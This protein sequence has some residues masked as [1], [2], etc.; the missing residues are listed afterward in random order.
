MTRTKRCLC[1]FGPKKKFIQF[2]L[3]FCLVRRP[4]NAYRM[5]NNALLFL[6]VEHRISNLIKIQQTIVSYGDLL[7][8][9]RGD[10]K[11]EKGKIKHKSRRHQIIIINEDDAMWCAQNASRR[12][13]HVA[14]TTDAQMPSN[15]SFSILRATKRETFV[16]KWSQ[17][18][19]RKKT[20]NCRRRQ[21]TKHQIRFELFLKMHVHRIRNAIVLITT[22][23]RIQ[24]ILTVH[25]KL[26]FGANLSDAI[27]CLT[28]VDA[29]VGRY[30]I[31]DHQTFVILFDIGPA[32][33]EK[34]TH[35]ITF[36]MHVHR[37]TAVRRTILTV[38]LAYF[39]HLFA[40]KSAVA[41]HHQPSNE[42]APFVRPTLLSPT[43]LCWKMVSLHETDER[44]RERDTEKK[45][46]VISVCSSR[47]NV[48]VV[49]RRHK[50]IIITCGLDCTME[51]ALGARTL[52][53]ENPAGDN[54]KRRRW[55]RH[56]LIAIMHHKWNSMWLWQRWRQWRNDDDDDIHGQHKFG[57]NLRAKHFKTDD[58][59][60]ATAENEKSASELKIEFPTVRRCDD[61]GGH[62][63]AANSKRTSLLYCY[64]FGS[65][66]HGDRKNIWTRKET[67]KKTSF[68]ALV[69]TETGKR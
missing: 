60:Q 52:R 68:F 19:S 27:M 54:K 66:A 15:F 35:Q 11:S 30:D 2:S 53:Y 39:R 1:R 24:L 51:S 4:S 58:S 12:Y 61:D 38:Q 42:I 50:L 18:Y 36:W 20:K 59:A 21:H 44:E 33:R 32:Q 6:R 43:V 45:S 62:R 41:D 48:F 16:S 7:T 23:T 65:V 3:T 57:V 56:I 25:D 63:A 67:R 22:S 26:C 47:I 5:P 40:I 31:F 13:A 69:A 34:K 55:R 46:H 64:L 28:Y 49:V 10:G 8:W 14:R 29:I 17:N 9:A 37:H